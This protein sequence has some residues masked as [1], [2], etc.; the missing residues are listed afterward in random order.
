MIKN[1]IRYLNLPPEIS[2]LIMSF[3]SA[4]FALMLSQ[5]ISGLIVA[6]L[7][8]PDDMGIFVSTSIVLTFIPILLIGVNNGLNRNLPY[9]LGQGKLDE[10]QEMRNTAITFAMIISGLVFVSILFIGLYFVF[11]GKVKLA[12]AFLATTILSSVY[13]LTAMQEVTYRTNNDF[14]KLSRIKF[15]NVF[16]A[17][18][19]IL[20]V[21]YYEYIG[22]LIRSVVI[23]LFYLFFLFYL[24]KIK[25]KLGIK[26]DVMK[27]LL[28][29][30]FPIALVSYMY[31][32]YVGLD[33]VFILKYFGTEEIGNFV[34]A[35]Q[36]SIALAVLPTSIFQIIYPRMAN[37]YGQTNSISSLKKLAFKPQLLLA[38]ALI[39]VFGVA[40]LLIG[41]FVE[42]VLPN[43]T[44]GI[45]AAKWMIVVVYLRC[46]GGPQDVLNVVGDLVPYAICT[47]ICGFVFWI[48]VLL[49]KDSA[50]GMQVVP[51]GLAI[52][53]LLF[54]V[55]ISVY[56]VCGGLSNCSKVPV[57]T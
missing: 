13:P 25:I 54:N 1:I 29:T 7:V 8:D 31:A 57:S 10:A 39:P 51:I 55:L 40:I 44:S 38:F 9:V 14:L 28:K 20:L 37:K 15:Y 56:V 33:K 18:G 21:I 26:K 49:L 19:T 6:R 34:P 47:I 11:Q 46:L 36:V 17:F 52:S 32:I 48:A 4:N 30:G 43:Y 22:M 50:L 5:G 2:K 24:S 42:Q 3:F 16:I 41:P 53:T 12:Y 23:A 45:P 35:I 27:G